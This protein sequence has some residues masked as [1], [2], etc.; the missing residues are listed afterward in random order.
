MIGCNNSY[1]VTGK[2]STCQLSLTEM[3]WDEIDEVMPGRAFTRVSG[4]V[5]ILD[6]EIAG[7]KKRGA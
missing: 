5:I 7:E 1:N 3:K 4:R 6:A 2:P